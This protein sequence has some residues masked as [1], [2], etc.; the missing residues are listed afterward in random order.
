MKI[1]ALDIGDQWVGCAISD[2]LGII[3]KPFK[4]VSSNETDNF[5]QELITNQK[6]TII[7][8]GYPIT[9]RGTESLQ[10]KKVVQEKERLAA[11]FPEISFFLQDERLSSKYA[12]QLSH[13]KTKEEKLKSHARAAAF[14]LETF[15]QSSKNKFKKS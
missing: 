15:L 12:A 6:V 4:T 14:I 10:T 2:P 7:V 11:L 9:M 1:A 5:I 8:I 3:A 13:A